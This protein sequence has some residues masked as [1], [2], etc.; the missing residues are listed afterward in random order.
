[1]KKILYSFILLMVI[2]PIAFAIES[3]EE[4]IVVTG[5]EIITVPDSGGGPDSGGTTPPSGNPTQENAQGSCSVTDVEW[6]GLTDLTVTEGETVTFRVTHNSFCTDVDIGIYELDTLTSDDLVE[7]FFLPF[8]GNTFLERSW[9]VVYPEKDDTVE[10]IFDNNP[11]LQIRSG[12]ERSEIIIVERADEVDQTQRPTVRLFREESSGSF[13]EMYEFR[14][15]DNVRVRVEGSQ[16]QLKACTSLIRNGEDECENDPNNFVSLENLLQ[17]YGYSIIQGTNPRVEGTFTIDQNLPPGAY[18]MHW[19]NSNGNTIV[20]FTIRADGDTGNN[21]SD[22]GE[23]IPINVM[24]IPSGN[25]DANGWYEHYN[26]DPRC[27]SQQEIRDHMGINFNFGDMTRAAYSGTPEYNSVTSDDLQDRPVFGRL[28]ENGRTWERSYID[29]DEITVQ[30][31]VVSNLNNILEFE[32]SPDNAQFEVSISK[33]PGVFGEDM[34]DLVPEDLWVG[35]GIATPTTGSST[36]SY[37][38]LIGVSSGDQMNRCSARDFM[39]TTDIKA[40]P[41]PRGKEINHEE[42]CFL[43]HGEMYFLNIRGL[44]STSEFDGSKLTEDI[45][46]FGLEKRPKYSGPIVNSEPYPLYY[47]ADYADGYRIPEVTCEG[48]YENPLTTQI[49]ENL[50]EGTVICTDT[51]GIGE[52]IT[53]TVQCIPGIG[54]K[55][56]YD[57]EVTGTYMCDY[58][59]DE[60]SIY[61]EVQTVIDNLPDRTETTNPNNQEPQTTPPEDEN[62][63][64]SNNLCSPIEGFTR[65]NSINYYKMPDTVQSLSFNTYE[66]WLGQ[67]PK[68]VG[69]GT[70]LLDLEREKYISLEFTVPQ[71]PSNDILFITT[72]VAPGEPSRTSTIS[73]SK[74]QGGLTEET[75][76]SESCFTNA[77]ISNGLTIGLD[78]QRV[79][80]VLNPGETYYLNMAYLLVDVEYGCDESTCPLLIDIR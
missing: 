60:I 21:P 65:Q 44:K 77:P 55:W 10:I 19:R 6:V 51:L 73:V 49:S 30:P 40:Y 29:T 11:R 4:S 63:P 50:W 27:P 62:T 34:F 41:V 13:S 74:C 33:C 9:E 37:Y 2:F 18:K 20:E 1:M 75:A 5:D 16:E 69:S 64:N 54:H 31:F 43:E 42:Y 48:G 66:E 56:S 47:E 26:V 45:I 72:E 12:G 71:N 59:R 28:F 36:L 52:P 68:S 70:Y 78:P 53:A 8:N 22:N 25:K 46:S 17:N 32:T 58:D 61:P 67:W 76:L 23:Y 35:A 38:D 15:G 39:L 14:S 3:A 7:G 79:Q 57:G 80:C 24:E